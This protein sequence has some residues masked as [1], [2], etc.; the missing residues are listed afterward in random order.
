MKKLLLGICMLT[1]V[2]LPLMGQWTQINDPDN[3][4]YIGVL[5]TS[6]GGAHGVATDPD[7]KI[8]VCNYYDNDINVFNP[9]GTPA[10]FSPITEVTSTNAEGHDS[11]FTVLSG[12]RGMGVDNNGNIIVAIYGTDVQ[13][14]NYQTGE[15]MDYYIKAGSA[16]APAIDGDGYIYIGLVVGVNPITLLNPDFSVSGEINLPAAP[17]YARGMEVDAD[18][19]GI[20][21]GN[22]ST[23]PLPRWETTDF[24][25][26]TKTDSIMTNADGDTIW[27]GQLVTVDYGPEGKLWVSQDLAYGGDQT[28]DAAIAMDMTNKQ[29]YKVTMPDTTLFSLPGPRGVAFSVT[30]DTMYV[31][32]FN[33]SRVFMYKK[34]AGGTGIKGDQFANLPQGYN[35]SQNYPNPFNPSTTIPFRLGRDG[36]VRVTVYNQLGQ[37]L[38]TLVNGPMEAGLHNVQFNGSQYASG[39]YLV[40]LQA[41]NGLIDMTREMLLV[42]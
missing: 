27:G 6:A 14:I 3:W 23:G 34:G 31:A 16:L 11:T 8:W 18:G 19:M 21:T 12:A 26:W 2:S 4:G 33:A 29:Y 17:S 30:G 20:W 25:N 41:E 1:M 40:R 9:D 7:G 42:K 37:K 35:L 5:D 24:V 22:L 39:M 28:L 32:S 13:R 36:N 10:S 38:E 15:G